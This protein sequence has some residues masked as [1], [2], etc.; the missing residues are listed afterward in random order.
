MAGLCVGGGGAP[1]DQ[2]FF[3]FM[4]FWE[5]NGQIYRLAPPSQGQ[6]S[7]GEFYAWFQV[8][9]LHWNSYYWTSRQSAAIE[10]WRLK[11]SDN[12]A[13][14]PEMK[15]LSPNIWQICEHFDHGPVSSMDV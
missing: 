11:D 8:I 7:L 6:L 13:I 3:I 2:S 4:Q 9:K 10:F 12:R 1:Q 5:K 15:T 14:W